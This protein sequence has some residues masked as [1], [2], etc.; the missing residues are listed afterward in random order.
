M[1]SLREKLLSAV[2]EKK[3]KDIDTV[4][5][6]IR[7]KALRGH[8]YD[9]VLE[10]KTESERNAILVMLTSVDP[11]TN[12]PVFDEDCIDLL[13]RGNIAPINPIVIAAKSLLY[14]DEE[15]A[16]KSTTDEKATGSA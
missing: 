9:K 4:F 13:S 15:D 14:P 16:K 5:G 11:E 10:G 12:D 7:V 8:E 1:A 3:F 6:K 2:K